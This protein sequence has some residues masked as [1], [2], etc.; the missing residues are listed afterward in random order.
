ME[1]RVKLPVYVHSQYHL[2]FESE[3]AK[4]HLEFYENS[5]RKYNKHRWNQFS[6][7]VLSPKDH[8][9]IQII[10]GLGIV[11]FYLLSKEKAWFPTKQ[12]KGPR[13]S[14]K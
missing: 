5:M 9:V 10:V 14:Y 4:P 2:G 11:C 3:E 12:K 1:V 6:K 13:V 8:L 7:A